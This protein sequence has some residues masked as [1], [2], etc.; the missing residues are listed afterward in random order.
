VRARPAATWRDLLGPER[1][2]LRSGLDGDGDAAATR[3]WVAVE[4]LQKAGV[5]A[6]A[7]LAVVEQTDDGWLTLA[8]GPLSVATYVTR[9]RGLGRPIALGVLTGTADAQL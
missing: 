2:A 5:P 1:T 7:P 4:C 8:C 6:A 3:I 9:V